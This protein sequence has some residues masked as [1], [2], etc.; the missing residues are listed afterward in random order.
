MRNNEIMRNHE[1]SWEIM[2]NHEKSWEI[3]RNNEVNK[4]N[5]DD[6]YITILLYYPIYIPYTTY[7]NSIT[8]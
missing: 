3:M 5:N 6:Y 8:L 4:N 2:R 7:F 1:K